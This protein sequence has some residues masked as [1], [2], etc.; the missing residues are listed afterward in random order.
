MKW[1]VDEMESWWNGKLIKWKVDE[2][3]SWWNE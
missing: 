2:M 3:E 1:K